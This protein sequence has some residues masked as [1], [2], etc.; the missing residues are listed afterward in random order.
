MLVSTLVHDNKKRG[1]VVFHPHP[2]G[3]M[4]IHVDVC[5]P[6]MRDGE[7][8]FHIHEYG[9]MREGCSSMGGHYNPN[10][11]THGSLHSHVRHAGDFGN[12]TSK[13]HCI[14]HTF[15]APHLTSDIAGR[16]LVLH[17]LADD[18]GQGGND[19]SRANGNAGARIACGIIAHASMKDGRT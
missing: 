8:G 13:D 11:T 17:A 19:G 5:I 3:G 14:K 18:L 7:H 16:G 1:T 15:H 12:L 4:K 6:E 10:G 2:T 9:D